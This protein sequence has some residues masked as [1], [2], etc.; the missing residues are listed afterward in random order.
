MAI[1]HQET[2]HERI[3][4][5]TSTF[6]Y[7]VNQ[8]TETNEIQQT[9]DCSQCGTIF[10]TNNEQIIHNEKCHA[11]KTYSSAIKI[12]PDQDFLTNNTA[13]LKAQLE[14]IPKEDLFYEEDVFEK[15]FKLILNAEKKEEKSDTM[16]SYNCNKCKFRASS[17]RCLSAHE[18]FVHDD[19]FYKCEN[20]PMR[21]KTEPALHYHI[22]IKHNIYWDV[23]EERRESFQNI[24]IPDNLKEY[25]P[26]N[27][28]ILKTKPDGLCGITCGSIHIFA[29]PTEGKQFRQ[30][31]NKHF[32]SHWEHYQHKISFPYERQ[33]GVDGTI[34]YR[35][36]KLIISGRI[37][38]KYRLCVICTK[39]M[40]QW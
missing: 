31:I 6:Q 18:A 12:V 26:D 8:T 10:S 23:E 36:Q 20:C 14:A 16:V 22:D 5:L 39:W 3:E 19:K 30:V 28:V 25:F 33:V 35:L 1:K 32:V 21:T 13:D 4:R 29:Q 38:K 11:T 7:M 40:P 9:F 2:P 17:N 15:D 34:F 37:V 27:H 24:Q